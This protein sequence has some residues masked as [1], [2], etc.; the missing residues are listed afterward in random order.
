VQRNSSRADLP[1]AGGLAAEQLSPVGETLAQFALDSADIEGI[2]LL[3]TLKLDQ[4]R[5]EVCAPLLSISKSL[6]QRLDVACNRNRCDDIG[7]LV[8]QFANLGL[9]CGACRGASIGAK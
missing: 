4:F 8:L 1:R 7:W 3:G 9:E 6:R 2:E 5:A